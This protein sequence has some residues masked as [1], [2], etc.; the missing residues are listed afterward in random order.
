MSESKRR[1]PR[2]SWAGSPGWQTR[3]A[4]SLL[5]MS[6]NSSNMRFRTGAV[7][8]EAMRSPNLTAHS[9]PQQGNEEDIGS[10]QG[11]T[12]TLHGST[13]RP[14]TRGSPPSSPHATIRHQNPLHATEPPCEAAM[15]YYVP[16]RPRHTTRPRPTKMD[17]LGRQ[18]Q[19]DTVIPIAIGQDPIHPQ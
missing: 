13:V 2:K 11:H 18:N 16:T 9:A 10:L 15:P 8:G 19:P 1:R 7:D 17:H 14:S 12:N 5:E 3:K 6:D 4:A